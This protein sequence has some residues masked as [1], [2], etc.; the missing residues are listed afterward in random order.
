MRLR[1]L[2]KPDGKVFLKSEWAPASESWPAVSYSKRTVGEFLQREFQPGRDAIVYVGTSNPLTTEDP[3]HRQRLLSAVSVEPN[4]ILETRECIPAESWERAQRDF[5]GRW[6]WSYPALSIFDI[7]GFPSAYD[8]IPK[9][10][11]LLGLIVNR[12]NVVEIDPDERE[13]ILDVVLI[14]VS[15]VRPMGASKFTAQRTLLNLSQEI[16]WEIGRIVSGIL[17]RVAGGD[18]ER[19]TVNPI[20]TR[21]ETNLHVMFGEKWAEQK[22]LCFLCNGPLLPGSSNFLLQCSPDR[23]N[24]QDPA[25]SKTNTCITH[26]G[27]N[28]AKNKCT[29]AEFEDWLAV[30]RGDPDL[31]TQ[32]SSVAP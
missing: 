25:Y 11:R 10:Y 3:Q 19:T 21:E 18:S 5:R 7:E 13:S 26:L 23:I 20:R 29:V 6:F 28:L 12:G 4:Q 16:R 17:N 8:V 27:C 14:P 32:L 31:T 9:S 15:F 30:V 2:V 22:G 1:D 24:S